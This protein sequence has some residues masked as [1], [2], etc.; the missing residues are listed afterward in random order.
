M[1]SFYIIEQLS[2]FMA[3][4]H[5]CGDDVLMRWG[6]SR[7][8]RFQVVGMQV[9]VA[10]PGLHRRHEIAVFCHEWTGKASTRYPFDGT[11]NDV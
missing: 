4:C 6:L 1:G 11:I 3:D 9:P 10:P 2:G 5:P 7:A 8:K